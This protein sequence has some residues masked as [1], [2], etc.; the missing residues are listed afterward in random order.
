MRSSAPSSAISSGRRRR[1]RSADGAGA[2]DLDAL[3]RP[4]EGK[5]PTEGLRFLIITGLS[6]AGK[7]YAMRVFEDLNFFCVDNL[8]PQLLPK[9]A[10]LCLHSDGKVQRVAVVMDIRGGEFFDD[11]FGALAQLDQ[12]GVAY[13]IL[14]L[15]ASDEALVRRFKETRRKHPLSHGRTILAGIRSERRRLEAV[16]ERA[17]KIIDTSTLSVRQ[18]REE[19]IATY[20]RGERAGALE[21]SIISFGYKYGLPMDADLVFD[22]RFLP[23]P[24]YQP[25]LRPLAGGSRE[26]RKFVLGKPETRAFLRHLF[27]IIDYLLPRFVQEGKTHLTVAVG[28]T[29]GKHRSVVLADELSGHLHTRGSKVR[30]RHRDIRK[31]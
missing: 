6:G 12:I 10:D 13:Q 3:L 8:P 30:V 22:V 27:R 17:D 9:F 2:L 5:R 16:K 31:E 23:N 11:L 7:S 18:L 29:G 19:I 24:H 26:V 1:G 15:D 4:R 14:F 20:V 28:C 21:I 25:A